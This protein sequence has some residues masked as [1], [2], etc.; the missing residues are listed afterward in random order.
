MR[1]CIVSHAYLEAAYGHVL[2]TLAAH[3]GIEL[4]WITPD[5]YKLNLQTS[6]GEA[7]T[8]STSFRT[9]A[10]PIH[11][12]GRQGTFVYHPARLKEA[13]DDFKPDL[14]FHEQEV[15]CLGA[16]QIAYVARQRR[17]PLVMF[18]NENVYR[19]LSL[20]RRCLTRYVLKR[21]NALIAISQGAAEVHRFWG[22]RGKIALLPQIGVKLDST[23]DFY[24]R[25]M[26]VL[27]VCYVGRL[28]PIK[29]VD[30]LL[31]ALDILHREGAPVRCT[32]A[33]KGESRDELV[34]LTEELG[35]QDIVTFAGM[36]PPAE[37][38]ALLRRSDVLVCPSR[39]TRTWEEQFGRVLVE[40]MAQGTI[41]A[42][43]R[44]GAIREVIGSEDLLFDQDDVPALAAVLRRL[45]ADPQFLESHRRRAW[46]RARDLY[47]DG[48]VTRTRVEF[49]Q[50]VLDDAKSERQAPSA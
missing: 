49:L 5:R 39:K 44:T 2:D 32:V 9:Y 37:V 41:A 26:N 3:P 38:K 10:L 13:L 30:C 23:P 40:A 50:T 42:G 36:L 48:V 20:P 28:I 33:G 35:L 24:P 25:E 19:S 15:F 47:E 34:N 8:A 31:R 29:G 12:G 4:A 21:C 17:I 22:F 6:S 45:A 43:S 14:I 27:N 1:L 7:S 46:T 18:V 16:T 11:W